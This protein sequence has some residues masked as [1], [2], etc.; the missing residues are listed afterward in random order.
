MSDRRR[1]L[2]AMLRQ[3]FMAFFMKVFATLEPGIGFAPNWHYEHLAWQLERVRRGEVRRLIINVPPRSGKSILASVAW[4]MFVMGQDPTRRLICVSHT[5]ELARKFNVDR[6][7]IA[8]QPWYQSLFPGFGLQSSRDLEFIT[9]RHGVCFAS[10]VGGAV[11]GKGADVIIIDDPIKALAAL[12]KAERRRVAEFYDN[13]L[14]TRLNDKQ[15]GAIVLIMQRLHEDDLVG[16]VLERDDWEVVTLPAIATEDC[17]FRLSDTPGDTY[18]RAVGEVL[19]ADREPLWVLEQMRRVQGGMLFQ[20]QYQQ[21]PV[22]ADGVVIKREWLRFY[23]QQPSVFER[24]VVSWDTASTLQE[25]SDYSVGT[26]WGSV[27]MD[28]YLLDVVRGRFET[29]DLRRRIM[30]LSAHWRADVTIVENTELGR[31]LVQDIRVAG[32]LRPILQTPSFDKEA[33]L[34]AQAAR[35]ETGQVHLPAEAP[36]LADYVSELTAFPNGRHDDQVDATSQALRYLTR[37][38][39]LRKP[40]QRRWV[41]ERRRLRERA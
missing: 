11:L 37:D 15:A 31:A 36:W 18:R 5:E 19:H 34:L 1:A 3:D 7:T 30:E 33:R 25:T 28:F 23:E 4:P 6:R 21:Q 13:T 39:H 12:S 16:H 14:V 26:V 2:E 8:Q 32:E 40:P 22:P 9:T 35:F 17:A 20:A 27:G 29:P 38:A 41:G 24:I 10:G